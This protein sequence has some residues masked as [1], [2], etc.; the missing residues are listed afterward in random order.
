[1]HQA[2]MQRG[3]KMQTTPKLI[4][5]FTF[6]SIL[7]VAVC[8][9]HS[10]TAQAQWTTPDSN[11]NINNTNTGNVGVGNT[12]PKYKLDILGSANNA[13]IRFGMDSTD[14]GGFLFSI[15]PSHATF[16]AGASWSNFGW[17]ARALNAASVT[18]DSGTLRFY[19]KIRENRNLTKHRE[20]DNSEPG[21]SE[22]DR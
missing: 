10:L 16:A 19:T 1:M 9:L 2:W 6:A 17:T 4:H 13:Q 14:S 21:Q 8:L 5:G 11:Q 15:Q 7:F 22:A 12:A 20:C 3:D 18:S